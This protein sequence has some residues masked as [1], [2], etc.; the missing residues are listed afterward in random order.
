VGLVKLS[1]LEVY[2]NQLYCKQTF[3][4]VGNF[5]MELAVLWFCGKHR[6]LAFP[7]YMHHWNRFPLLTCILCVQK[8]GLKLLPFVLNSCGWLR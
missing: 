1:Q 8:Q 4:S 5:C 2:M 3:S 7:G 6:K